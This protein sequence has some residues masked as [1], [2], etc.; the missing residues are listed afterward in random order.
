[1]VQPLIEPS[2][3]SWV[4]RRLQNIAATGRVSWSDLNT[5]IRYVQGL[6]RNSRPA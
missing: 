2:P 6:R 4:D 3:D 1:M 5:L